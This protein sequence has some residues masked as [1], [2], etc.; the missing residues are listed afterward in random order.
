[1][2]IRAKHD[3]ADVEIFACTVDGF[4]RR[5]V[6]EITFGPTNINRELWRRDRRLATKQETGD[7][8]K[9]GADAGEDCV[10]YRTVYS[11]GFHG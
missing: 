2:S 6:S 5:D 10:D 7:N 11:D 8:E 3:A 9:A 4:V 1:V